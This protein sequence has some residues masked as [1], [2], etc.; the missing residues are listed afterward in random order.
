[1]GEYPLDQSSWGRA[2]QDTISAFHT[3]RFWLFE[4]W[5][6]AALTIWVLLWVPTSV[7][8]WGKIVYQVL[9]P[10]AGVFAGLAGVFLISLFVA[11]YQQRNQ[12]W[13]LT[14][15]SEGVSASFIY[16]KPEGHSTFGIYDSYSQGDRLIITL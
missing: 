15:F 5:T 16:K 7:N 13:K 10:L 8:D 1:M 12:A 2:R 6:F 3:L 14:A 4:L 11:P 9:V